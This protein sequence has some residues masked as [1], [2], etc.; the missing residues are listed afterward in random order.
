M[1]NYI[2]VAVISPGESKTMLSKWN[3][4]ISSFGNESMNTNI[5]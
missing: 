2:N 1:N 5:K 3:L 4:S